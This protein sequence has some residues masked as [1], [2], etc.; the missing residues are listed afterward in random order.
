MLEVQGLTVRY[1]SITAVRAID[2][3]VDQGEIVGLVGANGAG[4]SSTLGALAGTVRAASGVVLLNGRHILGKQPEQIAR[5]G[6]VLVPEGRHIFPG[7]TVIE[8][9]RVPRARSSQQHAYLLGSMLERFPILGTYRDRAAGLLSGGE[10]QQLAIARAL[11]CQPQLLL[12]DEPSL[13]LAPQMVD[14]VF[15][16]VEEI[17]SS[18]TTVLIVEQNLTRTVLTADRSYILRQGAIVKAGRREDLQPYLAD[19][20]S[21]VGL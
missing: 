12:L 13:G 4:K 10:Q 9:L 11:L 2:L 18:G 19:A 8:N 16:L 20:R 6:M 15:T 1:G 5:E 14:A 7:L 17:R 21:A 3:R